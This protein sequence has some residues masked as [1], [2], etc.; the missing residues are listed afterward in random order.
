MYCDDA[1]ELL[2]VTVDGAEQ[3][4]DATIDADGNGINDADHMATEDGGYEYTDTN[5]DGVAD[6]LTQFDAN[7]NITGHA[8]F[9]AA[10]GRWDTTSTTTVDSDGDGR[11]DTEVHTS[12]DRTVLATD[13]DG[14]GTAD[15]VTE[16]DASGDFTTYEYADDRTWHATNHGNVT[17]GA[18][19]AAPAGHAVIDPATGEWIQR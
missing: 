12:G 17:E 18:P 19:A 2:S 1:A 11:A 5:E 3:T 8:V 7:G 9:D 13:T 16:I 4:Y 14:D 15:I 6:T 10:T